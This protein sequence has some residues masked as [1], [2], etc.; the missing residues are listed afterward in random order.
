[1]NTETLKWN[2]LGEIYNERLKQKR[3]PKVKTQEGEPCVRVI[4]SVSSVCVS[5]LIY[6]KAKVC[7]DSV[8]V[9][10]VRVSC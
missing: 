6:V 8:L 10:E 9:C 5:V 3:G 1:M 4:V 2:S 7:G